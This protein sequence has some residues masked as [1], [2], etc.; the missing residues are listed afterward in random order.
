[1]MLKKDSYSIVVVFVVPLILVYLCQVQAN[2]YS[3]DSIKDEL[4]KIMWINFIRTIQSG[5]YHSKYRLFNTRRTTTTKSETTTS[6]TNKI[7]T[8]TEKPKVY[9]HEALYAYHRFGRK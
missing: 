6:S 7:T 1:M 4:S 5:R 8:T 2:P 3:I 9:L